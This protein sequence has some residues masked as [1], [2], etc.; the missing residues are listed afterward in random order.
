MRTG[1]E[2]Q[3]VIVDDDEG[4]RNSLKWLIES[5]GFPAMTFMSADHF[6]EVAS[7]LDIGCLVL[8]VRMP[9]KS[10]VQLLEDLVDRAGSPPIVMISAFADVRTAVRAMRGGA[11]DF[12]EKPVNGE[13]L[14]ECVARCLSTQGAERRSSA[15]TMLMKSRLEAL[16]RRER[17]ILDLIVAGRSN[18]QTAAELGISPRTVEVHRRNIMRKSGAS[19]FAELVRLAAAQTT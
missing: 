9:G 19:S 7:D 13:E 5:G 17:Q 4:S 16:T 14:L 8:D 11:V 1:T 10:G 3:V 6:L 12:L 18:K 15:S 2:N